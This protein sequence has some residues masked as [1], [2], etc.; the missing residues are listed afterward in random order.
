M[1]FICNVV[2]CITRGTLVTFHHNEDGKL[3][4]LEGLNIMRIRQQLLD[5]NRKMD[6]VLIGVCLDIIIHIARMIVS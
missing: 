2:L 1:G 6:A 4:T 5:A 3:L